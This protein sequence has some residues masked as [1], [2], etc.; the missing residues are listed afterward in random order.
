MQD[1]IKKFNIFKEKKIW[2]SIIFFR[3]KNEFINI[4]YKNNKGKNI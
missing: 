2:I 3:I 1:I 4:K